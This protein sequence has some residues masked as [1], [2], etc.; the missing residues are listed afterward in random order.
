MGGKRGLWKFIRVSEDRNLSQLVCL[1]TATIPKP[2]LFMWLISQVCYSRACT[3][4]RY[5]QEIK[6]R[7]GHTT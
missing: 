2:R 7:T 4:A 5:T 6:G 1:S 3:F